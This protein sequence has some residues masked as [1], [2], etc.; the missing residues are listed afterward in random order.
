MHSLLIIDID[1]FKFVNDTYGHDAG[2]QLIVQFGQALKTHLRGSDF[3][4]RLGGDEF[5]VI[6][7]NTALPRAIE[8][9]DRLRASLP[10]VL[11]LQPGVLHRLNWSG[12][13]SEYSLKD[14]AENMALSR[15]DNALLEAKRNG[16]NTTRQKAA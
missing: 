1:N 2:D 9:S 14:S 8:L 13:L 6:F 5:C 3:V 10:A 12:G 4:A 16:R 15:A 11:E 7:P